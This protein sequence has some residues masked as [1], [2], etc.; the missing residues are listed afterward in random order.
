MRF[1]KNMSLNKRIYFGFALVLALLLFVG[2]Y[3]IIQMNNLGKITK[4]LDENQIPSLY[5]IE[6]MHVDFV[7]AQRLIYRINSLPQ[8]SE[9]ERLTIKVNETLES[10]AGHQKEYSST[11]FLP[12]EQALYD[13]YIAAVTPYIDLL[14]KSLELASAGKGEESEALITANTDTFNLVEDTLVELSVLQT[15]AT[16]DYSDESVAMSSQAA[17]VILV[18]AI[19]SLVIGLFVSILISKQV[20]KALN[21]VSDNSNQMLLSA[22][23]MMKSVE[24]TFQS[25]NTLDSSVS[26]TNTSI[27]EMVISI[28][29][30]AGNAENT[31][32][33]VEEISAAIEEMSKSINGVAQNASS[34]NMSSEQASSAISELAVSVQQVSNNA[35]N[36]S[37]T[38][39]AVQKDAIKGK[40]SIESTLEG[41]KDI[42][43]VI[44]Q[45]SDVMKKLGKS[46]EEIG[47]II[48]V[49]DDIADQTN[50]LALN[51]AIEAARAGEH[52]KGFA[53]VADEVRKLAERSA[54]ATKEIA[55]LIEGIQSESSNAITAIEQGTVKVDEG[56][57]LTF[58][59]NE[60]ILQIVS[61]INNITQEINQ[62]NV[63]TTQQASGTEQIVKAV[64]DV[65]SQANMVMQATRE[66]SLGADEIVRGIA[67]AREQVFQITA[68][69]REQS[70]Y[71]KDVAQE[72]KVVS[73][74][75]KEVHRGAEE[76]SM[77][78]EL[79]VKGVENVVSEVDKLR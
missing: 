32:S 19:T 14:K 25:V 33:S 65:N 68:A 78:T 36:V 42:S 43:K 39:L 71:G 46:S 22:N 35:K 69:T 26:K 49:I 57:K 38:A 70:Q 79:I 3:S 15:K 29:Q 56:S 30:T 51:A 44:S 6:E 73:E 16:N 11:D 72:M 58:D 10:F 67:H 41:M 5:N 52:G 13:K 17:I 77:K 24:D 8:L 66:Q 7:N 4:E 53:V 12:E 48:E 75:T 40:T 1:I 76:Q 23:D 34:L 62:I 47:S 27:E 63:A 50:L 18:L 60:I 9:K 55:S 37:D 2:V 45:A 59:A 64:E 20:R 28:S 21:S 54:K 31:A 61:S 74:Q